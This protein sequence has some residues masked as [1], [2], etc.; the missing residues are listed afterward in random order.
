MIIG[1]ASDWSPPLVMLTGGYKAG[2]S[3]DLLHSVARAGPYTARPGS[4]TRRC[5]LNLELRE[6]RGSPDVITRLVCLLFAVAIVAAGLAEQSVILVVLGATVVAVALWDLVDAELGRRWTVSRAP[7]WARPNVRQRTVVF[8]GVALGAGIV[9]VAFGATET[10]VMVPVLAWLVAI[11]ALIGFGLSLDRLTLADLWSG[12][13]P[14]FSRHHRPEVGSVLA[15]MAVALILRVYDLEW[16]PAFVHGDEGEMGKIALSILAGDRVPFFKTAPFWG[17]TYPFNYVQAFV[18][19]LSGASVASLRVVS[20]LS[21]VL[22]I[23][24]VYG[25]GRVG[26]GPAAAALACWLM[27]VSHL[28]NHYSRL[29]QIFMS[30]TL[31]SAITML[32]LAVAASRA[33]RRAAAIAAGTETRPSRVGVGIWTLLIG[34]GAM[35]GISQHIYHSTRVVPII[36][37]PLLLYMLYRGWIGRWHIAAFGFAFLVLY[38]PLGVFYLES[39]GDFTV[40]LRE[41][42]AFQD[43]Y[44]R[45]LFGQDASLPRALP[46]LLVEQIRRTMHLLMRSGDLSGFYSG[47]IPTFDVVTAALA[48][49]GL[50]AA[51]IRIRRYHELALL[52]WFAMGLFF[53]SV[54]T[55]GAQNA[56]RVLIVTPAVFLLG[57]IAL[58]RAWEVFRATPLRRFEWLAVPGGTALALWMLAANVGAY[59]YEY[60]PRA[61]N[62]ASTYM[63][64]EMRLE[65]DRY[66]YYF[67]T[68]P[69]FD[70]NHGSVRYVAYGIQAENLKRAADFKPPND[71]RGILV[72]ALED[73]V[74]DL[75]AIQ[76]LVPGGEEQRITSPTGRLLY[77]AYRVPPSG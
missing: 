55:L 41:V 12:V 68:S 20:V 77:L 35:A 13:R 56:H 66:R 28:H 61:E 40:R 14:L 8:G 36:A 6:C 27:A 45:D 48:W 69:H 71:G 7:T 63:A 52:V 1:P 59:F 4:P 46:L 22:M 9:A 18:L 58:T 51:V 75:R 17:P 33:E 10:R 19:W 29:A 50:G 37:G 26:W 23:P 60:A 39:P 21:G 67:L 49:L 15:I 25:L 16:L 24:V 32:L 30:A 57:A 31:L 5:R 43:W 76:A 38:A 72:L 3:G 42:S 64:R 62:V 54:T 11:G 44:V 34:A 2:E 47:S 73:H 74:E 65:P 53:G 70:P